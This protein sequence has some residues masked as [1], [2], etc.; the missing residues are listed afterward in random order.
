MRKKIRQQ[1]S[2][3]EPSI[4]HVHAAELLEMSRI[5][6]ACPAIVDLIHADLVR[7]L[8]DPDGGREGMMTAEQVFKAMNIKQMNDFSYE[9]LSFHLADSKSYRSFC[10]FGI[11]DDI[12]SA[13]T[14]QRDFKKVRPETLEAINRIIVKY[15]AEQGIEKGRKTRTDCTAVE[16]H[17][18][19]PTDSSLLEDSVRVLARLTGQAVEVF[20][21]DIPFVDHSRRAKKRALD[22]LNA[23]S[24]KGQ[25]KPYR[26]LLQVAGRTKGYAE[27]AV[28]ALE[29]VAAILITSDL[30]EVVKNAADELRHFIGLAERVIRQTE[31]RVLHGETVPCAEKVFSIF[32]PH[33]D[34]IVKD[35]RDPVFGH[36]LVLTGGASGLF[37]DLVIEEGNPAD[38]TLAEKMIARQKEIYGR[39]P[40]KAAFDG[41]F[42][43]KPNLK[44][45]KEMGVKDVAFHKKRGLDI[46][47][48]VKSTWVYKQLRRFRAGVEG[49]ISFIKRGFGLRRC[50]WRGFESFK[51]YAWTSVVTVNLLLLA[52]HT[53]A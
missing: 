11:A 27:A 1:L 36:K 48:M 18:H 26:D 38:S 31:R 4:N 44:R 25:K 7:G 28:A 32:E 12:P 39:V 47:E 40:L 2:F 13:S 41:G 24:A 21:L 17:I 23:K 50:M 8:D 3:V 6:D 51:A 9:T 42:A 33:T 53:L 35:R 49:M 15:A 16:T 22:I 5:I 20:D 19:H 14:L 37:I 30:D 45:I 34:I 52:R 46:G 43:S 10:G 29:V